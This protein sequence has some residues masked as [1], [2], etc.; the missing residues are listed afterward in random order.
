MFEARVSMYR[1]LANDPL[2][3]THDAGHFVLRITLKDNSVW[4]VD[5]AGAQHGQR[6]PVLPFDDYDRDYIAKILNVRPFGEG[7]K[8]PRD[9][10]FRRHPGNEILAMVLTENQDYQ[11][12]ELAEWEYHNT[13][14]QE[15]LKA[16]TDDFQKLKQELVDHLAMAAREYVKLA[17]RD[18]TS[19]AK[20][21]IV[22]H[23]GVENMSAEDKGRME[24]KRA[25]KL[26]GMPADV[27][28]LYEKSK[29]GGSDFVMI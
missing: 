15:V 8:R 5:L 10:I 19:K 12:D 18:S 20:L 16:K 3:G 11:I 1:H 24:R 14:V 26:A 29:A 7:A 9:F 22:K 2:T 17:M 25:R 21:I 13:T 28:E 6:K 4:A 23:Q 27:R